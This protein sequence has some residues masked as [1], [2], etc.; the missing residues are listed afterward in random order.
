MA[1]KFN[2]GTGSIVA[3]MY[4]AID[5]QERSDRLAH[6]K[7]GQIT[8]PRVKRKTLI[9]KNPRARLNDHHKTEPGIYRY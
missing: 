8:L 6:V 5:R 9:S 3:I 2:G 7:S 1:T 4:S